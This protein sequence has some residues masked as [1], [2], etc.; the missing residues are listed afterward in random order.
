M[1]TATSGSNLPL[2]INNV[3]LSPG[4]TSVI[5][6]DKATSIKARLVPNLTGVANEGILLWP[7]SD[8]SAGSFNSNTWAAR[9]T[10]SL[11]ITINILSTFTGGYLVIG[12]GGNGNNGDDGKGGGGGG[13]AWKNSVVISSG[14]YDAYVGPR[15]IGSF[16]AGGASGIEFSTAIYGD[17][18]Q[19]GSGRTTG[20]IGGSGS[21]GDSNHTGG[22][23]QSGA[24]FLNGS[25]GGSAGTHGNG[26]N[27]SGS[28]NSTGFGG[29]AGTVSSPFTSAVTGEAPNNSA[30]TDA[31]GG[32]GG[33]LRVWS[34][35][36]FGGAG[37]ST[38]SANT[39]QHHGGIYI[40]RS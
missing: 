3:L 1:L 10:R 33:G 30:N 2:T 5:A 8:F 36:T 6:S 34:I 12:G 35:E 29:V 23:G 18:G 4:V 20:G 9:A 25:G 19:G 38:Q 21:G 13:A 14:N 32:R 26:G 27:G 28:P 17:G 37:A 31:A 40:W 24:D 7:N 16:N 39:P 11:K 22:T 15:G